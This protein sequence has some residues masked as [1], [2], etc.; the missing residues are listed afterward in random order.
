MK[1]AAILVT[2]VMMLG[3]A[4]WASLQHGVWD[5]GADVPHAPAVSAAIA[6]ARERAVDR[7]ARD[8]AVPDPLATPERLRRGAGNY[9]AMC[10]ACH[11]APGRAAGE[12]RVGMQPQPP[13]FTQVRS[14]ADSAVAPAARLFWIT[15]HGIVGSGMPS[16]RQAGVDDETLWA[17]VALIDVMPDLS[18]EAYRTLVAQSS[19]HDHAGANDGHGAHRH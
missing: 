1:I 6:W 7:A 2:V 10:V 5:V 8:I 15:R 13:D 16:W 14:R 18:P 11:L 9:D 12:W 3:L 17:M 19:G 4:A